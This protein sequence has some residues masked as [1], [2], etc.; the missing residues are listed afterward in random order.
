MASFQLRG[1]FLA[2]S[3][4][5]ATT[6]AAWSAVI[7]APY[8]TSNGIWSGTAAGAGAGACADACPAT[9]S[10]AQAAN[11]VTTKLRMN[12]SS[13]L[14]YCRPRDGPAF[15]GCENRAL[16][17]RAK[18]PYTALRGRW[19]RSPAVTGV[20]VAPKGCGERPEG[21]CGSVAP[22]LYWAVTTGDA[23]MFMFKKKLEMPSAAEALPGRS[24][25]IPTAREHFVLHRPLK[26]PYP[27]GF[28]TAMFGMGCFWGAE[29]KFWELGDGIHITA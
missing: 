10:A 9:A 20:D 22:R 1:D 6:F 15:H 26:G 18:P 29:R 21:G 24:T 17:G 23:T 2:S 25:P 27:E 7:A 14:V 12:L 11:N 5:A 8:G 4:A 28:E 16:R 19:R 13:Q 3:T